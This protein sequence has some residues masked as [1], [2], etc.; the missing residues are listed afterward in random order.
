MAFVRK[1]LERLA[2]GIRKLYVYDA[3]ADAIGAVTAA[4]YF[5]AVRD[6]LDAKDVIVVLGANLT[7]IDLVFVTSA[8]GAA[9]V[10][11]LGTEGIT[12]T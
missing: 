1:N 3:G 2:G 10:T 11:T 12:A 7:T 8:R 9:S 4:D 5:G 6:E